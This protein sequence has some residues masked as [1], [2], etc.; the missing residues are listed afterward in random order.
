MIHA[1]NS[2][3][4]KQKRAA[5]LEHEVKMFLAGTPVIPAQISV[6]VQPESVHK[7]PSE[8]RPQEKLKNAQTFK[9]ARDEA[10][11]KGQTRYFGKPCQVCSHTERMT[12]NMTCCNCMKRYGRIN[13]EKRKL[14]SMAQTYV[15]GE[16]H[17]E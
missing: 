2:L 3:V 1:T 10:R 5:E 12:S 17:V 7:H 16:G 15:K 13:Y 4:L 6:N 8:S 11:A 9:A 14:K